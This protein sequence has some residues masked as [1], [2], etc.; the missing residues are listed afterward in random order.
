MSDPHDENAPVRFAGSENV[1][2]DRQAFNAIVRA[3]GHG[4]ALRIDTELHEDPKYGAPVIKGRDDLRVFIYPPEW[5]ASFVK[6]KIL[7]THDTSHGE[8][9]LTTVLSAE[10]L[11]NREWESFKRLARR[12]G[13]GDSDAEAIIDLLNELMSSVDSS[14]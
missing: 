1:E 5:E 3:L 7:T 11:S 10:K 4:H 12:M 6:M 2:F 8:H 9:G 13:I 14:A